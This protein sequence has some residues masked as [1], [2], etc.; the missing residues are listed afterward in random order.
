VSAA[1]AVPQRAGA[2]VWVAAAVPR[3][4]AAVWDAA[5]EPQ[6]AG[7]VVPPGGA[8][9]QRPVAALSVA[10]RPAAGR[11]SAAP[12]VFRPARALPSPVR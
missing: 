8:A 10:W 3:R 9:G 7:A 12:W 4:A 6:Q 2:E 11:P 1:A 5:E